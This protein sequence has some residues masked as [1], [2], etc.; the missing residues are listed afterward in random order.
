M[1][2]EENLDDVLH[3]LFSSNHSPALTD[4]MVDAFLNSPAQAPKE[5]GE[6]VIAFFVEKVLADLHKEP[7]RHVQTQTFAVWI[8]GIRQLARLAVSDIAL[9]IGKETAYVE[10]L[11]S[12][13]TLPWDLKPQDAARLVRLFRLHI[14]AMSDLIQKSFDVNSAHVGSN[15]AARAHGGKMTTNRGDATNRALQM[16]VARNTKEKP[17]D[18]SIIDWLGGVREQLENWEVRE[19]VD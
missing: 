13:L 4:S 14:R 6:R 19:L 3:E 7:V 9:A 17:L 15:V 16:F 5:S 10:R 11:E 8:Q 18:T 1:L 12:G 2:E